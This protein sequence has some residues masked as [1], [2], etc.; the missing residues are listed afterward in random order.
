MQI[1]FFNEE[2]KMLFKIIRN[3]GDNNLENY[4]IGGEGVFIYVHVH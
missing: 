1:K 2:I 3:L 4:S